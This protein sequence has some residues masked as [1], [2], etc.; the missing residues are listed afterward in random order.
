MT[1]TNDKLPSGSSTYVADVQKAIIELGH[2]A[3]DRGIEAAL[4]PTTPHK[5][6][7]SDIIFDDTK[8]RVCPNGMES[9]E[10]AVFGSHAGLTWRP[11]EQDE[12][13]EQIIVCPRVMV[14]Q[15]ASTIWSGIDN[16]GVP[17]M[18]PQDSAERRGIA[19]CHDSVKANMCCD[20]HLLNLLSESTQYALINPC[21]QHLAALALQ[22]MTLNLEIINPSYCT[23][24]VLHSGQKLLAFKAGMRA[25]LTRDLDCDANFVPR[26]QDL[27]YARLVLENCF[28]TRDLQRAAGHDPN[29]PLEQ[30]QLEE[31]RRRAGE[32]LIALLPSWTNGRKTHP[33]PAGCCGPQPCASKTTAVDR[34]MDALEEVAFCNMSTPTLIKWTALAPTFQALL[35]LLC[36]GGDLAAEGSLLMSNPGKVGKCDNVDDDSDDGDGPGRAQAKRHILDNK[37]RHSK[38]FRFVGDIL[39]GVKLMIW[40]VV[41]MQV[42]RLHYRFYTAAKAS[43]RWGTS[44]EASVPLLDLCQPSKSPAVRAVKQ[45]ASTT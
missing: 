6:I 17:V 11:R 2:R 32:R 23:V 12:I 42:M 35:V 10:Y 40:Q 3:Q 22:P 43:R 16:A 9:A 15:T 41:G 13:K 1:A 44:A 25:A 38:A 29:N 14:D 45:L 7:I 4:N 34:I 37:K 18:L 8:F 39:S 26:E 20:H 31:T 30:R 27:E 5:Y 21:R 33:C 28:Y 36:V 24:N 19:L